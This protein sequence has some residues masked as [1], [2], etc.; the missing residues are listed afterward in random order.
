[1]RELLE[2]VAAGELSVTE[3]ESRLS[4]YATTEAGRFD[5]ARETRRGVPEAIL[6][7]GKIP[8]EVATLATT[9][10]ETA[11]RALVTRGDDEQIQA[12]R[13]RLAEE[14]PDANVQV[15]ER[16]NIL[17]AHA[18]G[19]SKPDLD[20]T[21][22]VVSAGTSDAI[23]AGEAVTVAEEMGAT[24][25]EIHDVGVASLVRV[26]DEVDTLRGADVLIVAAG[27]EGA[28]PTVIAGLVN[29]P[30]IGLPVSNGYGH[31][32]QGK[33]ALMGMLQSCTV[34]STVNIDAG[35]V[36]GAQAGLI[37]QAIDSAKE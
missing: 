4:G 3:A 36:A 7:D 21:V 16:A 22:G 24:T 28:L 29:T 15:R 25:E 23:P 13:A 20:A 18:V 10:V 31:A 33:S 34:L 26:L 30:V 14:H 12:V 32:G 6:C 11:G 37:A 17:V 5:A 1:M 2:A 8:D 19:F 35:F 27:R 9:A